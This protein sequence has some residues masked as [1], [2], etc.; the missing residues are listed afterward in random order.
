RVRVSP[1]MSGSAFGAYIESM[2]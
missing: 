2:K 1:G